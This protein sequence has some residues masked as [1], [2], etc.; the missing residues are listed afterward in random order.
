MRPNMVTLS[1]DQK[2]QVGDGTERRNFAREM[3]H[4][5]TDY[6]HST[7]ESNKTN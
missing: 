5:S 2:I 6:T 4:L 3:L 1:D 7:G